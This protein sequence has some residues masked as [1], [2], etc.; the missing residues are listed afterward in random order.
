MLCEQKAVRIAYLSNSI[1]HAPLW[2]LYTLL[3]FIFYK[4]LHAGALALTLLISVRPG[5]SFF[6]LYWSCWISR[7]PEAIRKHL[8]ITSLIGVIPCFLFPFVNNPFFFI[9][10]FAVYMCSFRAMI[11]AWMEMLKAHLPCPYRT[12]LF[13]QSSSITYLIGL[14]L[15]LSLAPFL[16]TMPQ[17]WP[18]FFSIAAALS[19]LSIFFQIRLPVLKAALA[20]PPPI[21][22]PEMIKGP[23]KDFWQ[24][25][26]QRPDFAHFQMVFIFGGLGLMV[27][28]PA[29]PRFFT[30]TLHLSYTHM[31]L[32][33]SF[34]KGIG[35]AMTSPFWARWMAKV[36]LYYFSFVVVLLAAVFTACI[37]LA[38][39][40]VFWIYGGYL[41]YGIMQ[42][43]SELSWNLSGPLFA[44]KENSC[45]F[46]NVNL[47]LVAL[48]GCI[49]PALGSFICFYHSPIACLFVA[50]ALCLCAAGYAFTCHKRN[51]LPTP[52]DTQ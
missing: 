36:N 14:F 30:D 51:L 17:L 19:L 46:T 25:L 39:I 47:A 41:L 8:I 40:N 33:L 1:L 32:A 15:P 48:R 7:R 16:D 23:W 27:L 29:L 4:D 37:V 35:F 21:C 43:G 44:G 5:V 52:V 9:F 28:Q 42:A 13:S 12:R 18:W 3:P 11:P 45:R 34:C 49:G 31:A 26:K 2:A 24:L 22:L 6:S 20:Q 50:G 38:Q 10:A